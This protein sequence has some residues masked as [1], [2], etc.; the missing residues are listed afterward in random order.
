MHSTR[1]GMRRRPSPRP[2]PEYRA[3][4]LRR[5]RARGELKDFSKQRVNMFGR[6]WLVI[7][8]VMCLAGMARGQGQAG[9]AARVGLKRA[10]AVESLWG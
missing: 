5:R 9:G 2:L 6:I 4:E 3:R 1:I 8:G 7:A 10:S